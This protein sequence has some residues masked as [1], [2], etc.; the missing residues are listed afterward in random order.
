LVENKIRQGQDLEVD[1]RAKKF[2]DS[3][4][5]ALDIIAPKKV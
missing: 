2:V 3:M 5:E 4:V 1:R